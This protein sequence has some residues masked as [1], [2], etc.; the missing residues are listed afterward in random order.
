[1][2]VGALPEPL[3][4]EVVAPPVSGLAHVQ[5][6]VQISYQMHDHAQGFFLRAVGEF[7]GLQ[8]VQKTFQRTDDV[9][10]FRAQGIVVGAAVAHGAIVP[11]VAVFLRR[12]GLDEIHP[13]R[14]K[15]QRLVPQYGRNF[16]LC[17]G[18]QMVPGD[19]PNDPM[20]QLPPGPHGGAA[21]GQSKYQCNDAIFHV[22]KVVN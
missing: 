11:R 6:L 16:F 19:F 20:A 21:K 17:F 13:R 1:M 14:R 8:F 4:F 2:Q 5:R 7:F 15:G 3:H 22:P 9:A 18:S 12:V 10:F